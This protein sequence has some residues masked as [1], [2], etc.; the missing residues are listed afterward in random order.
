MNRSAACLAATLAV[1]L[2]ACQSP[3]DPGETIDV[4]QATISPSPTSATASSGRTYTVQRNNQAD[5]VREYDWKTNFTVTVTLTEDAN[6]ENVNLEL[7]VELTSATVTVQQASGGIITPPTGSETEHYDFVIVQASSNQFSSVPSNLNLDFDVWYD[8]PNLGR[9]ALVTVT[10]GF[11]DANGRGFSES[12]QV[13]V[14][15]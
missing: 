5:E 15:N 4:I 14:T 12:V 7:P 1:A 13:R 10:L 3:T 8:L 2:T 6:D 11:A 9:E